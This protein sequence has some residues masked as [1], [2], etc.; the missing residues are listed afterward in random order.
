MRAFWRGHLCSSHASPI[1]DLV[2]LSHAI[3]PEFL[4][5]LEVHEP[6]CRAT[7]IP[8]TEVGSIDMLEILSY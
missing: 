6:V 8:S 7:Y 4:A 5:L 1:R 3:S 2:A